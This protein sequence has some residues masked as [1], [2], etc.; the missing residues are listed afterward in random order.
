MT[1]QPTINGNGTGR[2]RL[3]WHHPYPPQLLPIRL[4]RSFPLQPYALQVSNQMQVEEAEAVAR[5]AMAAG[6]S[7]AMAG[8]P[9]SR[10]GRHNPPWRHP[11]PPQ[12]LPVCLRQSLL[13]QPYALEVSNRVQVEEAEASARWAMAAGGSAGGWQDM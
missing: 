12:L 8:P 9:V 7:G 11:Y 5:R 2:R 4:C 6:R 1:Q 10:H 3:P 13:P